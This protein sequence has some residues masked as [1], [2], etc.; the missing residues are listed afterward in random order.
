MLQDD[1]QAGVLSQSVSEAVTAVLR[2]HFGYMAEEHRL[3]RLEDVVDEVLALF[4]EFAKSST[5]S[6]AN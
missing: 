1:G 4:L 6:S 5:P 3:Y 2:R